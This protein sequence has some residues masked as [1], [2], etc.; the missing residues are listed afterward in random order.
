MDELMENSERTGLEAAVIGMAGRFP[1]ADN[2]DEFWENLKNGV[3]SV[4]FFSSSELEEEGMAPEMFKKPNFIK[5]KGILEDIESFDSFFFDYT[6]REAEIM[7]PQIRIFHECAWEAFENA[8]YDPGTYNGLAGVYAG[9]SANFNWVGR[10]FLPGGEDSTNPLEKVSLSDKDYLSMRISYK[11][12]LKGPSISIRTTCSTSLVAVHLAYQGLV[13]GECDVALAG[14]VT[15]SLPWRQGYMYQEGMVKSP[16]GHCRAFDA[17]GEGIMS[18]NG[19]GIVIL[20]RLPEAI[21]DGDYIHAVIRGTA[22]NND[23]VRKVGYTAPSVEGQAEVIRAALNM[24]EVEPGSITYIEAHGTGTPL[25]DPIEIEALKKGFGTE[26]KG[27]CR[28]GSVK[29]NIGHLDSA[30]GAAGLIKTI[31]S[32]KHRLIP[33]SLHFQTPNPKIDFDNSPFRVNTGLCEWK[34]DKYPLRAGVSSFGIGGTNAHVILEEAPEGTGGLAPLPDEHPSQKYQLILLSAKT[35]T[36]LEKMTENL[37]EYLKKNLLNPGNP[38]NPTNPGQKTLLNRGNHQNPINPGPTLTDAAYTLQV[39][40][41][42]FK[43]R[44]FLVAS[45]I[46]ETVDWLS[47]PNCGK[48]YEGV[49]K[50]NKPRVVFMFSGQGNQYVN[51]GLE[52]YGKEPVF[53]REMDRCFQVLNPIMGY[54]LKGILYPPRQTSAPESCSTAENSG[55]SDMGRIYHQEVTQPVMF[56]FEYALARLLMHW[57]IQPYAMIG[58]SIGEYVAACLSGVFSLEDALAVV[59]SRGRLMMEVPNGTMLSVPLPEEELIPLLKESENITLAVDN[60]PSCIVSGPDEAIKVFEGKLK[61][62]RRCLCMRL[63]ISHAGHSQ[64]MDSILPEFRESWTGV[65]FQNPSIPYISTLT[66]TWITLEQAAN[67]EYW[68]RH[69]RETVRFAPGITELLK[70]KDALFLELGPGRSLSTALMQ[71]PDRKTEQPILNLIRYP[72]QKVS[73]VYYLLSKIGQLW[74]SGVNI[75]WENLYPR[76]KRR[77]I[78]LPTYSFDKH[79]YPVDIPSW[80]GIINGT[81]KDIPGKSPRKKHDIADWFYLPS[82]ESSMLSLQHMKWPEDSK[83]L[84]FTDDCRLGDRLVNRLEQKGA[85]VVIIKRGPGFARLKDRQYAI[86]PRESSDYHTLLEELQQQ[87]KS[88]KF[89]VH[90]WNVTAQSKKEDTEDWL[91]VCQDNGYYSLIYLA[92]AIG[93][94]EIAHDIDITIVSNNMQA[95]PGTEPLYPE[96]ATLLG[97]VSVLPTEYPNIACRSVDIVLPGSDPH[98]EKQVID[99]LMEEL[100]GQCP[101]TIVAYRG[102]QRL[103]QTFTP[104]RPGKIAGPPPRLEKNGV[105][106][107]TGGLGGVGLELAQYLAMN[108]QAKLALMGRTPFP[109]PGEWDQWVNRHGESDAV[110]AKIRKLQKMKTKG[111]EV[112]VLSADVSDYRQME[113]VFQR[114]KDHFGRV[115]GVIHCAM[116]ADGSVIHRIT[117][118]ITERVFAPKV[119]GSLVLEQMARQHRLDFLVLCSSVS[120]LSGNPG[121][122]A[123]CAANHFLDAFAAY[124]HTGNTGNDVFTVSINWDTWRQVGG[125]VE[126]VRQLAREMGIPGTSAAP[127][128]MKLNKNFCGGPGGGFSKKSPLAVGN[129]KETHPLLGKPVVQT[130]ARWEY[131]S[132]LTPTKHWPLDEHRIRGKAT[133]P[134]TAYLE[135]ARAAFEHA[136]NGNEESETMEIP[137]LYLLTPLMVEEDET[138]EVRIILEKQDNGFEFRV[139]S[140]IGEAEPGSSDSQWQEHARG[141]LTASKDELARRHSLDELEALCPQQECVASPPRESADFPEK[142]ATFGNRWQNNLRMKRNGENQHLAA[143]ELNEAFYTDLESYKLHPALLDCALAIPQPGS[144]FYLPFSY[145]GV[146]ISTGEALPPRLYS[147]IRCNHNGKNSGKAHD[148]FLDYRVSIMDRQGVERFFI[149]EYTLLAVSGHQSDVPI[150]DPQKNAPV[151]S[152]APV[153]LEEEELIDRHLEDGM[154]PA[155][156][157]EVFAR[158]MGGTGPRVVVSTRDLKPRLTHNDTKKENFPRSQRQA[159]RELDSVNHLRPTRPRPALNTRYV[160][161]GNE[162]EKKL[163][164]IWGD[165][166]GIHQ[167]GI[168]DNFFDLGATSLSIIQVNQIIKETSGKELSVVT[169]YVYPTIS[170]LARYLSDEKTGELVSEDV[171]TDENA[172]DRDYQKTKLKK[173]KAKVKRQ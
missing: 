76:E 13:G 162:L 131:I 21:E 142:L 46:E 168:H 164:R 75:H 3:E 38:G 120:A 15:I 135:I 72:D 32:L 6:S 41:K 150:S 122:V 145:K 51:M 45:A 139:V 114:V 155:E 71:H 63:S 112:V 158:I 137:E 106:L 147:H 33:P 25:G 69:L 11:L 118:E 151:S 96:K 84:V 101:D 44:K 82:W 58:Y 4:W 99:R 70:E 2:L 136:A 98:K 107:I 161:P 134:G 73:D 108:L 128:E 17:L 144:G 143:V 37:T 115:N 16:D 52:L 124:M 60:G 87:G 127:T 79:V 123:Y 149:E 132:R 62:E 86:N 34:R 130:P 90:L 89:I 113:Q 148:K 88:F 56:V 30:A 80:Q 67:P 43:Y 102:N 59:A 36:A 154:L 74:L 19:V 50:G 157:V 57:G 173:R 103:I 111:A 53:R 22:V 27:F 77:R 54:D 156:G 92:R 8:G 133:L 117:P 31:L 126:V 119:K 116:D 42:P 65:R 10:C 9:A 170:E 104:F 138:K 172:A 141:T 85:E 93:L 29:T 12:G 61:K 129:K 163:A 167:V 28:I 81:F 23:G 26:K 1:G 14:G 66:G 39:G 94:L 7:D 78:P 97:S 159:A 169:M 100:T 171:I 121:E 35:Q 160:P 40:R 152:P 55:E 68:T 109:D 140:R 64:M 18:G 47:D 105:C 166:L 146:K 165:F 83:W 110:S 48:V 49:V 20:K 5:A 125:A 95:V 91:N 24:A 153:F